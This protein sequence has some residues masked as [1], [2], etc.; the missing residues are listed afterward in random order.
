MARLT[1]VP[2]RLLADDL[3]KDNF[4]P[5]QVQHDHL[6][7]GR[8]SDLFHYFWRR[9]VA[10]LPA[11]NI[12][13][14]SRKSQFTWP[15]SS[16]PLL[17][18]A[19]VVLFVDATGASV[20]NGASDPLRFCCFGTI[21]QKK[22]KRKVHVRMQR[23]YTCSSAPDVLHTST[24]QSSETTGGFN[25]STMLFSSFLSSKADNRTTTK[26]CLLTLFRLWKYANWGARNVV[27]WRPPD[28]RLI[29]S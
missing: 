5:L 2:L 20:L 23:V 15:H 3:S 11:D 10:A 16:S 26:K 19:A 22:K 21:Q 7:V 1:S 13:G 25:V 8:R 27:K 17:L 14:C 4:C 28:R 24:G 12:T 29:K 18:L 9:I 6:R